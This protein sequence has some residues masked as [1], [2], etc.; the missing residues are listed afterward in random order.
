MN[1]KTE[2]KMSEITK[3]AL[4]ESLKKLLSKNKLNKIT[5]KE[6]TEDCGVNRQ[7]F[8]YHF[9]DIYDLVEWSCLEDAKKA[10]EEKKTHDTW[11]EGF[12]QIFDA[13]K[14]NKPFIMN[15]YNY[16]DRAQVEVY[17]T[18]LVDNLL[19]GVIEEESANISVRDED[20]QFIARIY[21]YVFIGI[22]LDWIK[23]GMNEDPVQIVD[24]LSILLKDSIA[25]ALQK[26]Q[27]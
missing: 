5:I 6:I 18:P 11:Q 20:K 24:K 23:D 12:I 19:M 1:K 17:L 7:T 3:K 9:K 13:V 4:A 8:Y 16:I 2:D 10:L 27:Y 15:V 26:F 25:N 22:M 14:N 21:G